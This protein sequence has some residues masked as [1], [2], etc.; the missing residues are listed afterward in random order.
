MNAYSLLPSSGRAENWSS[1]ESLKLNKE[2]GRKSNF[3]SQYIYLAY[4]TVSFSNVV[5]H[6]CFFLYMS[7][8]FLELPCCPSATPCPI[9]PCLRRPLSWPRVKAKAQ[10]GQMSSADTLSCTNSS[11]QCLGSAAGYQTHTSCDRVSLKKWNVSELI[12]KKPL[13][14]EVGESLVFSPKASL[15]WP[16]RPHFVR[17]STG[18]NH[19]ISSVTEKEKTRW[20]STIK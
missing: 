16:L 11:W 6:M 10:K 20:Q 3:G 14:K 12:L 4:T 15:M 18:L 2:V 17:S 9:R 7:C 19:M 8:V 5:M 1:L 13:F